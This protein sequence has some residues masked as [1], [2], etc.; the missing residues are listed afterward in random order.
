MNHPFQFKQ[1]QVFHNQSS[2]KIGT[3]ATLLG[4]VINPNGAKKILDVG[5]GCGVISLML[6]QKTKAQIDA[7][8]IDK[9]SVDEAK[10]NFQNSPWPDQLNAKHTS[11]QHFVNLR[12][13]TYDMIIS[14]PPFFCNSLKNP[15]PTKA[16]ARHNDILPI[17]QL[18]KL[19]HQLSSDKAE[20]WLI[21]PTNDDQIIQSL[22]KKFG[23]KI[24]TVLYI[25]PKPDKT[26][27]RAVFNLRK[28][29]T[30]GFHS[31][32][33]II[34]HLDGRHTNDYKH[35]LKDYLLHL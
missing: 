34:R 12:A 19:S 17:D 28:Y 11:L 5:T 21:L 14:N 13:E 10:H 32:R 24:H 23:W 16:K 18:L 15:S 9:A 30:K 6:A 4:A 3:D 29:D 27:N 26:S 31:R 35:L 22:D 25:H 8:D 7:I 20:M 1:F 33:I 2:I